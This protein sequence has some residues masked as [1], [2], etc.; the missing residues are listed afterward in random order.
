M[1]PTF[2]E[3]ASHLVEG[4]SI[5]GEEVVR[6]VIRTLKEMMMDRGYLPLPSETSEDDWP[7]R[8]PFRFA[9]K[10]RGSASVHL[11]SEEKVPVKFLRQCSESGSDLDVI[12]SLEGPTPF[13]KKE[14]DSMAERRFQFFL[15]KDLARNKTKH[16]LVPK[17]SLCD[18]YSPPDGITI[19]KL[20]QT[21]P[22]CQYYDFPLGSIVK[23]ERRVGVHSTAPFY[24]RVSL[25]HE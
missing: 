8:F 3:K 4:T 25:P 15:V 1:D 2:L 20:L 9:H 14:A 11:C 13:T 7:N 10:E 22:I 6:T 16:R 19:P 12:V 23:I 24:R 17:H 21:D 5:D 18:D